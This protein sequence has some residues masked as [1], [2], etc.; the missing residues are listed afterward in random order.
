LSASIL[1]V[2]QET[3]K[4]VA[5]V[6]LFEWIEHHHCGVANDTAT[7]GNVAPAMPGKITADVVV[8]VFG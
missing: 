5:A 7:S 3:N 4:L 1:T 8:M 2:D 6:V